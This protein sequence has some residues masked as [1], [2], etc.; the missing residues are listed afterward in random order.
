MEVGRSCMF[1]RVSL[2]FR[3]VRATELH[4]STTGGSRL[5][6]WERPW[7]DGWA[8]R[9]VYIGRSDDIGKMTGFHLCVSLKIHMG[10]TIQVAKSRSFK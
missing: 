3:E 4:T 2:A 8:L 9:E 7:P 6:D 1:Q 5:G 10:F